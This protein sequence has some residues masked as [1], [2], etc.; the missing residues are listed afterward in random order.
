M[1]LFELIQITDLYVNPIYG[2]VNISLLRP[3]KVEAKIVRILL[4]GK[5]VRLRALN[6]AKLYYLL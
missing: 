2:N 6:S 1:G 4:A 5:N 3:F